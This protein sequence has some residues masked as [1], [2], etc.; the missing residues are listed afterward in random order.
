MESSKELLK[1]L[2][3]SYSSSQHNGE[4]LIN[5]NFIEG[6]NQFLDSLD[7][8][9][10]FRYTLDEIS[11]CGWKDRNSVTVVLNGAKGQP[12]T[13]NEKFSITF[14]EN[15]NATIISKYANRRFCFDGGRMKQEIITNMISF[16]MEIL[17]IKKQMSEIFENISEGVKNILYDTELQIKWCDTDNSKL[18]ISDKEG[19]DFFLIKGVCIHNEKIEVVGKCCD[20][21]DWCVVDRNFNGDN[22]YKG[23]DLFMATNNFCKEICAS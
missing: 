16:N 13:K 6:I 12:F 3:E 19:N 14:D 11:F 4:T 21:F 2:V 5:K 17:Y 18:M 10:I 20:A 9:S 23:F 1:E 8:G 22:S 15:Y 7:N